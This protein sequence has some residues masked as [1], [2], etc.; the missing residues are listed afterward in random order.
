M[1]IDRIAGSDIMGDNVKRE[2]TYPKV[3]VIAGSEP[4]G[5][6]GVQADIKSITCCGAYAAGSI[7]CIVNEDT[8]AVKDIYPLPVELVIGQADSFLSDVGACSIKIG[9]LF[10]EELIAGVARN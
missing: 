4:L 9:M 6:A 2:K 7:T 1:S 3:L 8:T 10:T 5:S